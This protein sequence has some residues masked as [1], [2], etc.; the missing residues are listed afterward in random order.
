MNYIREEMRIME[1]EAEA[2]TPGLILQADIIPD[3]IIKEKTNL[4]MGRYIFSMENSG[5][6]LLNPLPQ[7]LGDYILPVLYSKF[8]IITGQEISVAKNK[9]RIFAG[10]QSTQPVIAKGSIKEEEK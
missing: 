6:M 8:S 2:R 5:G 9:K 1:L 4:V 10:W 7:V 3:V